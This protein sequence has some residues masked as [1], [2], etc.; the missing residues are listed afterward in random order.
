MLANSVKSEKS[1]LSTLIHFVKNENKEIPSGEGLCSQGITNRV[2]CDNNSSSS[3]KSD[4]L[5]ALI[6]FKMFA[7]GILIS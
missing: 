3:Y 4:V 1:I 2:D 7:M 6:G 5:S